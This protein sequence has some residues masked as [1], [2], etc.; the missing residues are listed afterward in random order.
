MKVRRVRVLK[1]TTPKMPEYRGLG[2]LSA[3]VALIMLGSAFA[4]FTFPAT[5]DTV[6]QYYYSDVTSGVSCSDDRVKGAG[7]Y[8]VPGAAASWSD[9][10]LYHQDNTP[11]GNAPELW[12]NGMPW[13]LQKDEL[14]G[15]GDWGTDAAKWIWKVETVTGGEMFTGDIVFF[16]QVIDIPLLA[17]VTAVDLL[18]ACDN[19]Y[20]VYVNGDWTGTPSGIGN[21]APVSGPTNFYYV[22]DGSDQSG[23]T[24]SVGYETIGMTYPLEDAVGDPMPWSNIGAFSIQPSAFV[25]G[26]NLLQIVAVNEHAPWN[27]CNPAGL[28]YKLRISYESVPVN[29]DVKPGSYPNSICLNDQGLLPVA[30]LGSADVDVHDINP[31]TVQANGLSIAVTGSVKKPHLM[32]SLEDVN[33]DGYMD[34]V[35]HFDVQGLGLDESYVALHITGSLWNGESFDGSDSVRIV[36]PPPV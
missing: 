22:A 20:Y 24:N 12:N 33:L 2:L 15:T 9:A 6:V 16:Q 35:V 21:F 34:M 32:W 30:I 31:A 36:V 23:G 13:S 5:A 7:D 10:L 8:L 14:F 19:A 28:V 26:E 29:V 4:V 27:G 3:I 1:R 17:S 11:W 25:K 18:I